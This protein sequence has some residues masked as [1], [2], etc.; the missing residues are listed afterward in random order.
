MTDDEVAEAI[1]A[2]R[3]ARTDFAD[4]EAKRAT[5]DLP[6]SVRESLSSFSNTA[7]G[8]IIILGLDE[9]ANFAATGVNDPGRMLAALSD[10][11]NNNME[12]PLRPVT[13]IHQFEG[14]S[15]VVVEVPELDA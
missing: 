8:G 4:I 1:A 12:P 3:S 6:R 11:C 15:L 5:T 2:L 10:L 13:G 9:S 14:V 7:G